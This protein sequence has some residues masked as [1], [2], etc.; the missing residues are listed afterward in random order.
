MA[1]DQIKDRVR[2]QFGGSSTAYA[3]SKTHQSGDDLER[4]V[5]LAECRED[6]EALD[7]ATGAGHTARAIAPHVAHVVLSDLTPQMLDT[8][9]AE[10]ELAGIHNVSFRMADAEDLPFGSDTFHLATCRIAPHHFADA[11]QFVDEVY[12]VLRPGGL[13]LL[14]DSTAPEDPDLDQFLNELELRRDPTHVR[15][16]TVT[17]WDQML[18]N[19]GFTVELTEDFPKRHD[20]ADWTKRSRMS[21][22]EHDSLEAWLKAS[23]LEYQQ[24]FLVE[25]DGGRVVAFTDRKTLFKCRRR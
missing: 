14:L 11:Q 6:V 9:R 5:A 21:Q 13:F 17:E 19:A 4:I 12:R 23:P 20:F 3:T 24:H 18:R 16:Y 1:D 15:S 8:A 2:Q 10:L 22:E 7:I 25:S